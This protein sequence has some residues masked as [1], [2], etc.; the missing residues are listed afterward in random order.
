MDAAIGNLADAGQQPALDRQRIGKLGT[1][2]A[3][4]SRSPGR[5]TGPGSWAEAGGEPRPGTGACPRGWRAPAPARR[6]P[7][8]GRIR[9]R[10]GRQAAASASAGSLSKLASSVRRCC[11]AAPAGEQ[12]RRVPARTG[13][14]A[15]RCARTSARSAAVRRRIS[16]RVAASSERTWTV[17]CTEPGWTRAS[18]GGRR[19]IV[20][21]AAVSRMTGPW[22][23]GEADALHGLIAGDDRDAALGGGEVGLGR[24]DP[25]GQR[26]ALGA[27]ARRRHW[28][29]AAPGGRAP[30][31]G[32]WPAAP[33]AW[34]WSAPRHRRR[35][36]RWRHAGEEQGGAGEESEDSHGPRSSF[37]MIGVVRKDA[38][39]AEELLGEHR[40]GEQMR[41]GRAAEGEQEV[42]RAPVRVA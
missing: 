29:P 6:R 31:S 32:R 28:S 18:A 13:G 4:A 9:P 15:R 5:G 17:S 27:R 12:A 40:A 3:V 20:C 26:L 10:R 11:S 25:R 41:P 30:G 7:A 34:P 19:V 14:A 24:L 22:R 39:R 33:R 23:V 35:A 1:P 37:T 38:R 2:R 36:R 16:G 8:R 42:G 21:S